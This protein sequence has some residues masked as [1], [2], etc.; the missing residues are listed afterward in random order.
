M[1]PIKLLL[2]I[3]CS[4]LM[5]SVLGYKDYQHW[6]ECYLAFSVTLR[7][8]NRI[9]AIPVI[10]KFNLFSDAFLNGCLS[11]LL[12]VG[13]VFSAS[14]CYESRWASCNVIYPHRRFAVDRLLHSVFGGIFSGDFTGPWRCGVLL[15]LA[16]HR[17]LF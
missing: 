17:C 15:G 3:I 7:C 6:W 2:L 8:G 14:W 12:G 10:S 5:S 16:T 11:R 1:T 4:V 9:G 13:A